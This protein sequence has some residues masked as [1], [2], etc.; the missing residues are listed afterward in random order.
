MLSLFLTA[1]KEAWSADHLITRWVAF[2]A[3]NLLSSFILWVECLSVASMWFIFCA[4]TGLLIVCLNSSGS[5]CTKGASFIELLSFYKWCWARKSLAQQPWVTSQSG[6]QCV[7]VFNWLCAYLVWQVNL[8]SLLPS[9]CTSFCG[10]APCNWL[11]LPS[12]IKLL[13]GFVQPVLVYTAWH[14]D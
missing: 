5:D 12:F 11:P 3:K 4:S 1:T 7:S 2:N 13:I 14:F 10:E 6:M 9:F 8:L